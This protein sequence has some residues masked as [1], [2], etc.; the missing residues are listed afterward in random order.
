MAYL[1]IITSLLQW[2]PRVLAFFVGTNSGVTQRDYNIL[3]ANMFLHTFKTQLGHA[4]A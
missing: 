4:I 3:N 1:T 2:R